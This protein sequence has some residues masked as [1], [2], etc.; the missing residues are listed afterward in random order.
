M[1]NYATLKWLQERVIFWEGTKCQWRLLE[2]KEMKTKRE[3]HIPGLE[4]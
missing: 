2:H 3:D 4:T 1:R